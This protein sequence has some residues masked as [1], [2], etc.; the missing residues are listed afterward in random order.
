MTLSG[1]RLDNYLTYKWANTLGRASAPEVAQL[2][3]PD[4]HTSPKVQPVRRRDTIGYVIRIRNNGSA[5]ATGVQVQDTI[6][7]HTTYNSGTLRIAGA[8]P[9][10]TTLPATINVGTINAGSTKDVTFT[11]TVKNT[12]PEGMIINT[13]DISGA[14]IPSFTRVISHHLTANPDLNNIAT[15]KFVNPSAGAVRPGQEV[16]YDIYV[17]NDGTAVAN[18]V[19]V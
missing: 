16:I 6:S 17:K 10:A 12:A 1:S 2:I 5:A 19:R 7:P 14:G 4:S 8:N 11:V 18:N 15:D 3:E 9:F 13:A